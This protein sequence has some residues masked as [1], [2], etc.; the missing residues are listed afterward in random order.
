MVCYE[1]NLLCKCDSKIRV[2]GLF[3]ISVAVKRSYGILEQLACLVGYK[4]VPYIVLVLK[5]Q[6]KCAFGYACLL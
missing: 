1:Y 2:L 5:I 4:S 3:F 6:V